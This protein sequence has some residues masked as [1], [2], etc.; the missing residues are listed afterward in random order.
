M[1]IK[2]TIR[3]TLLQRTHNPQSLEVELLL[4]DD[5][6]LSPPLRSCILR[7]IGIK[8]ETRPHF[9]LVVG[10]SVLLL[11]PHIH[12]HAAL[13]RRVLTG[14]LLVADSRIQND[15][16]AA[17]Y[18]DVSAI[19]SF[20]GIKVVSPSSLALQLLHV[21]WQ[22]CEVYFVQSEVHVCVHVVNVT[23]LNILKCAAKYIQDKAINV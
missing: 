1:V 3:C 16:E 19:Q 8:H 7:E 18:E 23:I 21:L 2:L 9:S 4:E 13:E 12:R 5:A 10:H 6:F 14:R 22:T 20:V 15:D 11:H 17:M